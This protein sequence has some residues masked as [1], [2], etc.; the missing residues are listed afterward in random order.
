[1][2]TLLGGGD[3]TEQPIVPALKNTST[4]A[5]APKPELPP[6]WNRFGYQNSLEYDPGRNVV[7][8]GQFEFNAKD[9]GLNVVGKYQARSEKE[10]QLAWQE[11]YKR[12]YYAQQ[13]NQTPR[14]SL[15]EVL[16]GSSR[17]ENPLDFQFFDRLNADRPIVAG[18]KDLGNGMFEFVMAANNAG[19]Y[20]FVNKISAMANALSKTIAGGDGS[21]QRP[22]RR[23]ATGAF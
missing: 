11:E 17:N 5:K 12:N 7:R 2:A 10:A 22:R 20:D 6:A 9:A 19:E 14:N 1:M 23:T 18:K 13:G 3:A 21:T 8:F 4:K 15:A 16:Y